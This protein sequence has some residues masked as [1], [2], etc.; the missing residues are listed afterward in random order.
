VAGGGATPWTPYQAG[1]VA[2]DSGGTRVERD[3]ELEK[4]ICVLKR[5]FKDRNIILD[6]CGCDFLTVFQA[7]RRGCGGASG[8]MGGV[9]SGIHSWE[10]FGGLLVGGDARGLLVGG[11]SIRSTRRSR[12]PRILASAQ[13]SCGPSVP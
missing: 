4:Q 13:W 1:R 6:T 3:S 7:K 9:R 8:V 11:M 5:P 10:V 12:T 2:S